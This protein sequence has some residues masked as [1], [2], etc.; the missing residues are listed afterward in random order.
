MALS[1]RYETTLSECWLNWLAKQKNLTLIGNNNH[2]VNQRSPTFSL[3]I[4]H[5]SLLPK[6][7][8]KLLADKNIAVQSGSF[9]A[10]RCLNAL[11]I[12]DDG[13]L[14]VSFAHFNNLDE[15]HRLCHALDEILI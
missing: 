4:N 15:V 3:K 13:L 6:E 14:R 12:G 9:Y 10:W 11:K 8:A 7:V 2:D 1:V 5:P